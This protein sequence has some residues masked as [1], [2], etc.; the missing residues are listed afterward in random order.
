MRQGA[1][2]VA[3]SVKA[4]ASGASKKNGVVMLLPGGP[5]IHRVKERGMGP[6][7]I[8]RR[9]GICY[10]LRMAEEAMQAERAFSFFR[11]NNRISTI[12]SKNSY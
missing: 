11:L 2:L 9:E 10:L 1:E 7:V 5:T 8:Q 4:A 12:Y 3:A 6:N